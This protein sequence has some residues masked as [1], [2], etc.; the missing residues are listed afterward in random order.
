MASIVPSKPLSPSVK[1]AIHQNLLLIVT[2]AE[3][4]LLTGDQKRE[5]ERSSKLELSLRK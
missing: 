2:T 5:G 4:N 3:R 1:G